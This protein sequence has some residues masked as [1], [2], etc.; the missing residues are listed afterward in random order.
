M[1]R[2]EYRAIKRAERSWHDHE[3]RKRIADVKDKKERDRLSQ[4]ADELEAFVRA[5]RLKEE[6]IESSV[7]QDG[8]AAA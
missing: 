1:K 7:D 3:L 8:E 5:A 4:I 2:E 6:E